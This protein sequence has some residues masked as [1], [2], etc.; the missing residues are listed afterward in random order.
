MDT[1]KAGQPLID[2]VKLCYQANRPLLLS[3]R[4]GVGKSELLQQAANELG[5]R[6]VCR[7]LSLME[8]TD[9]VGLPKAKGQATTFL[10]PDFLPREGRGLLAFE[11]LNRCERYMRAPCLQLM[12]ARQL[13]DYRLPPGWL[14]VAAINPSEADYEV[15]DLDPALLSRFIRVEIVPD[16]R[17][18]LVWARCAGIHTG[19]IDYVESDH[20]VFNTAES[21][22]RSWSAVSDILHAAD[23]IQALPQTVRAAVLGTVGD[24]RGAAF[25]GTLK[26]PD[27]PLTADQILTAYHIYQRELL[28]W[29]KE[30]QIDRIQASLH[31]LLTFLQPKPDFEAVRKTKSEWDSLGCFLRDLPGDLRN[32]AKGFFRD[33]DYPFPSPRAKKK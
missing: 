5:V 2:L 4:H 18:W 9:L 13:N 7:D 28:K 22:P 10:P 11:E 24:K 15:S 27:R 6:F 25:L 32:E 23:K 8:P 26:T 19:V 17:E 14:P 3:G 20:T 30:G 16:R 1:V 29:V 12:T 33:R 21:N 31:S